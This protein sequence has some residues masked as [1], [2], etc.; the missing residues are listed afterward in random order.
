MGRRGD[1]T[2]LVTSAVLGAI[3]GVRS[4]AAPALLS[5]EMADTEDAD[6]FGPL[7]QI[8]TSDITARVMTVLAGGE[9]LADKTADLPDRTSPAPLVGRALIG[10]FTA[11]A[12]AVQRRHNVVA[13]ALVGGLS[14]IASTFGAFHAR[15]YFREN[16]DVP[17]AMLGLIEDGLVLAAS[18]LV[19]DAIEE[20]YY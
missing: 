20:E 11:A 19:V 13:P 12:F 14:A 10:A 3:T 8:L 17:D 7:E 6:E 15:R 9:A 5:H 2:V 16:H 1:R 4:M 18:K